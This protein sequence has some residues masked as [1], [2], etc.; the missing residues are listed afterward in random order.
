VPK[1]LSEQSHLLPSPVEFVLVLIQGEDRTALL[2]SN[3]SP[4][5]TGLSSLVRRAKQFCKGTSGFRGSIFL[6]LLLA[7]A[8]F[9]LPAL[10]A[11]FPSVCASGGVFCCLAEGCGSTA[12]CSWNQLSISFSVS[13][14][15][16]SLL[17]PS[18]LLQEVLHLGTPF[19]VRS[20]T[21]PCFRRKV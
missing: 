18:H 21:C 5:V 7:I 2:S 16:H 13:L 20:A 1:Y 6:L 19:A 10:L 4:D 14:I 11:P 12:G 8:S 3:V 17:Q 15:F 9:Y